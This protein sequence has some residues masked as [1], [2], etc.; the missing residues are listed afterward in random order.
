MRTFTDFLEGQIASS[1]LF[2]IKQN[3]GQEINVVRDKIE[4]GLTQSSGYESV[5]EDMLRL[6][7]NLNDYHEEIVSEISSNQEL[8]GAYQTVKNTTD[9][10]LEAF[11]NP[12]S[13]IPQT[14]LLQNAA[15]A[16]DQFYTFI[17]SQLSV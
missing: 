2:R 16:L 15:G 7:K 1:N 14:Q 12:P 3:I 10:A 5:K 6:K 4:M 9:N 17:Q 11:R 13:N 8:L